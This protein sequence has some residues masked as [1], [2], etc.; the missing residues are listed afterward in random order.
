V[1]RAADAD[2]LAA[3]AV[4]LRLARQGEWAEAER[5]FV[6]LVEADPSPDLLANTAAVRLLQGDTEDAI[7]LYEQAAKSSRSAVIRF[8]LAQAYGRAIRLDVQDIVLREAQSIDP[9]VLSNLNHRYNGEDGA[10]V[11]YLPLPVEPVLARLHGS[12]ATEAL[13]RAFR[14]GLAP[15]AVGESRGDA[16][17]ALWIAA[18]AGLLLG[19]A[20]RRLAGPEEDLYSGIARL[21]QNRSGDSNE[22]MAQLHELRQ[23][24]RRID[25][26]TTAF[27]WLV[28]GAAGMAANRP[29][30]AALSVAVMAG[31]GALW[32]HRAGPV[33]D[34]L[35]LGVLPGALIALALGVLGF[36]YLL[37]LGVSLALREKR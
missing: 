19:W 29:S 36:V 13:A 30:L 17:V 20:V 9:D 26:A 14:Q 3:R 27:A 28:P 24:Q 12:A 23:R 1:V 18:G 25:R 5:R 11:A 6:R 37:L 22:R 31:A 7:A 15:G 8:N 34:P 35:A 10:L 4:A 2:P 33:P 21:L 16:V 32:I